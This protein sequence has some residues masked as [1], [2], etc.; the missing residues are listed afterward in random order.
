M[1]ARHRGN[2]TGALTDI[3]LRGGFRVAPPPESELDEGGSLADE[4]ELDSDDFG[5]KQRPTPES[6]LDDGASID[7][8][9]DDLDEAD[10]APA[11]DELP[12]FISF[13][14]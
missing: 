8:E 5:E 6:E 7:D 4:L 2:N 13:S 11:D 3:Q 1:M 12:L 9:L 10:L 14:H